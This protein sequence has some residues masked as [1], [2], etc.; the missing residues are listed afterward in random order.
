[1]RDDLATARLVCRVCGR[2]ANEIAPE[3][4]HL[5]RVNATGETPAVWECEPSCRTKEEA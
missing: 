5:N 2:G 1:M 3:G 4:R